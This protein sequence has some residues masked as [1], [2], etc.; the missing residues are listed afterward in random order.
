[1]GLLVGLFGGPF[2]LVG[3]FGGAFWWGSALDAKLVYKDCVVF[4][5]FRSA[6]I[7]ITSEII[8]RG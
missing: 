7:S 2:F 8:L 5:R 1:M 3:L 4:E 6:V